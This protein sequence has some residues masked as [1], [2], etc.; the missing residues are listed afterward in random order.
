MIWFSLATP[1]VT[2]LFTYFHPK[3]IDFDGVKVVKKLK[4]QTEMILQRI[5]SKFKLIA[6]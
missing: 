6:S 3:Q 2:Q 5:F 4:N 1:V